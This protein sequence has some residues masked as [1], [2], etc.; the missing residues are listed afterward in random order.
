VLWLNEF[1]PSNIPVMVPLLIFINW[2]SV[3]IPVEM[4]LGSFGFVSFDF[5]MKPSLVDFGMKPF[6]LF[7]IPFVMLFVIPFVMSLV[8]ICSGGLRGGKRKFQNFWANGEISE[9]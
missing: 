3:G 9:F 5:G 8:V 4:N 7:V 6:V 1:S 2:S